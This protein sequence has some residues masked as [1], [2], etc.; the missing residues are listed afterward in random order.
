MGG[1]LRQ[2]WATLAR[3]LSSAWQ[4]A[5]GVVGE[6]AYEIYLEHHA[7]T[8]AGTPPM[9]EREFWRHHTDRGDTHPGS[10]CC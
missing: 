3:G 6:R 10:R 2:G 1:R 9:G 7:R 8:H 4:I 5:R